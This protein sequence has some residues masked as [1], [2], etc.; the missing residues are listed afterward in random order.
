VIAPETNIV[1]FSAPDGFVER[2]AERDVQ[3][4]GTPD[5]RVRAVTHLDVSRDEID[6]ALLAARDALL[7]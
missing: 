3:L 4:S 7:P 2:M 5:G 6:S 1:I